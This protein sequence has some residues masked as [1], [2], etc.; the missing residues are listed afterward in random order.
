M[1]KSLAKRA[2]AIFMAAM[3]GVSSSLFTPGMN[4]KAEEYATVTDA[5]EF[6][7]SDEN[8][9]LDELVDTEVFAGEVSVDKSHFPDDNFRKYVSEKLDKDKNGVLSDSEI[10]CVEEINVTNKKISS[11]QGIDIFSNLK[12]LKC[13]LNKI[14][15][16][17][18]SKNTMLIYLDCGVNKLDNLNISNNI[19]LK[20]LELYM[21]EIH[22]LDVTKNINLETLDCS[23]NCLSS[24]D[25]SKNG[26]L[27]SLDCSFNS[28]SNLDLS[29]NPLLTELKCYYNN[30][31]SI[32][33]TNNANLAYLDCSNNYISNLDLSK[34]TKI[35][36]IKCNYNDINNIDVRNCTELVSLQCDAG[37]IENIDLS[38][39]KKLETLTPYIVLDPNY[40]YDL[41]KISWLKLDKIKDMKFYHIVTTYSEKDKYEFESDNYSF[42]SGSI[43][44]IKNYYRGKICFSYEGRNIEL[45][46]YSG[47]EP[48]TVNDINPSIYV[49]TA[50][51][52]HYVA[53]IVT[54]YEPIYTRPLEYSWIAQD[55][56]GNL[57]LMSDWSRSEWVDWKPDK[58]GTYTIYARV[59]VN[60]SDDYIFTTIGQYDYHPYIKGKCQMPYSAVAPGQPG[61]LIGVESYENP[62]QSFQFEMLILDC[63][64]LAQG[65][66][67][68]T[69]T[70]GKFTVPQG[71]AGWCVWNPQYGYYWTLFRIYDA[72]GN[73]IDEY[74]YP[75]VNAY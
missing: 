14:T 62:N 39:N 64:L 7:E 31:F 37:A 35:N 17:D 9:D 32:K 36:T 72:A 55:S 10:S 69:Y 63:T 3:M 11:L 12:K 38:N 45:F 47:P 60:R 65:L 44:N 75:F 13:S 22:N 34:N 73:I 58:Y 25:V 19:M 66:P 51:K 24:L 43:I 74:C 41:S 61:Y 70:T 18:L 67:A 52:D 30:M 5:E 26:K 68:W 42:L 33:I 50:D 59:R 71:N 23:C 53:G 28:I 2:A 40:R 46:Y 4:V 54:T 21:C 15:N 49:M 6:I 16:L 1:K 57:I 29:G 48:V 27:T 8:T 20:H 56:S